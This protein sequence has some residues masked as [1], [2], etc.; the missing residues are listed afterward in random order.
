[1]PAFLKKKSLWG[2]LL[3]AAAT[4]LALLQ[5]GMT[6]ERAGYRFGEALAPKRAPNPQV[7]VVAI[8]NAALKQYGPWPW[9]RSYLAKLVDVLGDDK[10]AVIA[11]TEDLSSPQNAAALDYLDQLQALAAGDAAVTAKLGEAQAALDTDGALMSSMVRSGRVLLAARGGH[12]DSTSARQDSNGSPSF[13]LPID[14]P[15]APVVAL[16]APLVKFTN[17]ARGVGYLDQDAGTAMTPLLVQYSGH[18]VPTLALLIAAREQDIELS[19]LGVQS[20]GG[21]TLGDVLVHTD[22]GM[23]VLTEESADEIPRY[24]FADVMSGVTPG[25]KLAGKTVL[26]G[27]AEPGQNAPVLRAATLVSGL[28]NGDL[29]STPFWAWALRALLTLAV[30]LYLMLLLPRLGPVLSIAASAALALALLMGEYVPLLS[31][32]L[33]L[34]LM[35]PFLLLIL[36]HLALAGLRFVRDR[37]G[38]SRGAMSELNREYA[39]ALQAL[40]RFDLCFTRFKLCLPSRV[41]CDNLMALGQEHERGRRYSQA[42]EVYAYVQKVAPAY[43]GL[44]ERLERLRQLE[45][46][47]AMTR[48][49]SASTL[50]RALSSGG[51]QKPMLGR[52]ELVQELGRGAMGV[53]YLGKDA[54]IGRQVAIKTMA[55]ADEFDGETLKEVHDRFFREA[56]TAGRLN[57]ANIVT[58][59]DVG[60]DQGL[61]YI[62]M[63]FLQGDSL[64]K[65]ITSQTL[66]PM[67]EA[68]AVTIKVAEGLD[69]AHKHHVV[70]RDI[71]PANIMYDRGTGRVKITDFGIA[72]LTDMSKTKTGTILGSPLYMSPEQVQG[73]KLDGRSD[74]YSLGVTLYQLLRG[75]LPFE[76]PSLTGLMFK[77]ANEPHP[78]VTFL[79]PDIP[80]TVKVVMDKALQKDPDMR[81]Q[82][83]MEMAN[84]LRLAL[85]VRKRTPA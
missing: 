4:L 47:P 19:R 81:F 80:P 18:V 27:R 55:L 25:E 66:L 76:A 31:R 13:T 10:A 33:W 15:A 35:L 82:T 32:E 41:L 64:A 7:V 29:V 2:L 71:K 50:S 40:N 73:H 28:L 39:L 48:T 51:L 59:Y 16:D 60:E 8:D 6:P 22:R 78:D 34:P 38:V 49:G 54:K 36:G 75:E 77:I 56:E 72:A 21:I 62:A 23:Q 61:A 67:G 1:M 24:G 9:P 46:T 79:R 68:L 37:S 69:Y 12:L 85:G 84:A 20:L 52:Y 14:A 5:G 74:L 45:S 3:L 17:A 11:L 53:V 65:F 26:V 30:G 43:E 58:I 83:G 63:D 70:H 42:L 44:N 57:H